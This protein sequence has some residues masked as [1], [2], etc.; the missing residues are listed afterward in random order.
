[1]TAL[2]SASCLVISNTNSGKGW[3]RGQ[4]S[5]GRSS[6]EDSHKSAGLLCFSLFEVNW[7][8]WWPT[9]RA[10]VHS[11]LNTLLSNRIQSTLDRRLH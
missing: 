9:D 4:I 11:E 10:T 5:E 1:M 8:V 2:L 7:P 3:L 6:E